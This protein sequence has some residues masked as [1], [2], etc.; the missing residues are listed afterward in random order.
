MTLPDSMSAG[1][2]PSR[3]LVV[4]P[5][6]WA[7]IWTFYHRRFLPLFTSVMKLVPT[8]LS[9]HATVGLT[10]FNAQYALMFCTKNLLS[11]LSSY[12]IGIVQGH[13]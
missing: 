10:P 13:K 4:Q 7:S 8:P 2:S 12:Y 5:R 1:R 3:S 9:R 11:I 6:Y